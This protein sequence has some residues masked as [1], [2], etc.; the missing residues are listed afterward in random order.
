[1][2]K[3]LTSYLLFATAVALDVK[4]K[5]VQCEDLPLTIAADDQFKIICADSGTDNERCSFNGDS[6]LL[7]GNCKTV[8]HE[9]NFNVVDDACHSHVPLPFVRM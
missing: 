8:G 1:M 6:A 4:L 5:D 2:M 7:S 9:Y 3:L